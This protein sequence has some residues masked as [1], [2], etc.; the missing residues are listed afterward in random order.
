MNIRRVLAT[1]AIPFVI[2]T[3]GFAVAEQ[4]IAQVPS[5]RITQ[6]AQRPD[7][8]PPKP[9]ACKPRPG[10]KCPPPQPPRRPN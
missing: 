2:V 7:R 8:K 3:F 9:K 10:K 6:I 4:A 5:N 1:A